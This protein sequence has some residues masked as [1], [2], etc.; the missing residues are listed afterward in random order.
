MSPA[1]AAADGA[2]GEVL[3]SGF[4]ARPGVH[5]E[6]TMLGNLLSHAGIDVSEPMLFGLGEGIDFTYDDSPAP[7]HAPP[8]LTGRAAAG[9]VARSACAALGVD[10]VEQQ[11][12]DSE[13]AERQTVELLRAGHAVGVT[14]DIYHLDYFASDMHFS[15][16][17]IA[18]FGMGPSVA[19]V[20][21]TAQQG[22]AQRLAA[23]SLRCARASGEGYM[24][25]PHR[26]VYVARRAESRTHDGPDAALPDAAWRAIGSTADRMLSDRGPRAGPRAIRLAAD[27]IPEWAAALHDPKSAIPDL[28]RF[29]RYAGTGGTNFRGLY[30]DFLRELEDHGRTPELSLAISDFTAIDAHWDEVITLLIDHPEAADADGNLGA[31]RELLHTIAT[32]E[33]QAFE[34]LQDLADSRVQG[35]R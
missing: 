11:P 18:V 27:E 20:V 31:V 6:T 30:L 25:T 5:C 35:W 34:R 24:P 14:V 3:L 13:H 33:E 32:A 12:E 7:G 26:Q 15:A 22:G 4:R 23:D 28:G 10:L 19:H 8:F 1:A 17:C 21:D 9:D 2:D 29:W 16:H